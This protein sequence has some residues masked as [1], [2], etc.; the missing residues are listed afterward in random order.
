RRRTSIASGLQQARLLLEQVPDAESRTQVILVMTD[1]DDNQFE[2][3]GLDVKTEAELARQ[4][5]VELFAIGVAQS[6]CGFCLCEECM[7]NETL[8]DITQSRPG[9]MHRVD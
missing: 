5:G 6:T 4:A 3:T 2:H 7:S 1:G 8:H 9:T